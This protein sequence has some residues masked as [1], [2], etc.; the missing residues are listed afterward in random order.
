MTR[1]N[2]REPKKPRYAESGEGCADSTDG[3]APSSGF[4]DWASAPHRIATH[5]PPR[6]ASARIARSVTCSQPRPRCEFE[7]RRAAR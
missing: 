2:G 6:A 5:G 1:L 7:A 3:I 4:S